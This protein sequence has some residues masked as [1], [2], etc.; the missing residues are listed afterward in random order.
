[1]TIESIKPLIRHWG[2]LENELIF[3]T[4]RFHLHHANKV[5]SS[6]MMRYDKVH[7]LCHRSQ[8]IGGKLLKNDR[9]F[10]LEVNHKI[11]NQNIILYS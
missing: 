8:I 4:L 10:T 6:K 2:N 7:N 1:M 5:S 9:S 11:R 3:E